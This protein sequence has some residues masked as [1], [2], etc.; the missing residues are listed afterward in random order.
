MS[1]L[2]DFYAIRSEQYEFLIRMYQ[3]WDSARNLS[4]LPNFAFSV[5]MA[6]FLQAQA[7][8]KSHDNADKMV[9]LIF[10]CNKDHFPRKLDLKSGFF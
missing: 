3:E 2:I 4:Q 6:Y 7:E 10:F 5:P 8:A 9:V 1:L